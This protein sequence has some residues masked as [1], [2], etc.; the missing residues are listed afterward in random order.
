MAPGAGGLGGAAMH[1]RGSLM[2]GGGQAAGTTMARSNSRDNLQARQ[3]VA[4]GRQ[5]VATSASGTRGDGGI[6]GKTPSRPPAA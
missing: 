3:S 6:Y 2:P 5:S 1:N 4:Q